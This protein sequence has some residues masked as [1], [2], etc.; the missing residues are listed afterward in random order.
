MKII[1][2]HAV[3]VAAKN[4]EAVPNQRSRMTIS[5]RRSFTLRLGQ[6]LVVVVVGEALLFSFGH[7][8]LNQRIGFLKARVGVFNQI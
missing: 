1:K 8:L 3:S 2:W 6:V 4:K 5:R 7:S